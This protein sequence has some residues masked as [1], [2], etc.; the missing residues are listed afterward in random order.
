MVDPYEPI[1]LAQTLDEL[2]RRG[3]TEQFTPAGGRLRGVRSHARFGADE[4]VVSEYHRFEGVSDPDDMSIVYALE[5]R[6]GVRGT[7]TDAFGSYADPDVGAFMARVP[8]G[9]AGAAVRGVR[10][11]EDT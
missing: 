8:V 4:V 11:E 10:R 3:F 5:T 7:L 6:T 2:D 1:T 9:A